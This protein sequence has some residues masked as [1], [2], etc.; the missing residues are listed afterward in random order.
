M[1]DSKRLQLEKNV[2]LRYLPSNAFRFMDIG[3]SKPY[4]VC[5]LKTN[6]GKIYTLRVEL[7]K[8]PESVPKVFVM[9]MLKKKTGEEMSGCSATMHTLS[10]ENGWTRICHY[11]ND[12]TVGVSLWRVLY[13]CLMWLNIYELH[14]QTG[15][16]IDEYLNHQPM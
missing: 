2:L 13:K 12:W 5:A 11:G 3:T 1:I 10:S 16:S 9:K 15:A 7:D 4:L 6:N 14:L 8:F